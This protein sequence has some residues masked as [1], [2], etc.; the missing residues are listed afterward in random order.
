MMFDTSFKLSR[1]PD[2]VSHCFYPCEKILFQILLQA[3][4]VGKIKNQQ[5]HAGHTSISDFIVMF[6]LR[7]HVAS[8]S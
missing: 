8:F 2:R 6:K 3:R 4:V 5:P 7:H 1:T